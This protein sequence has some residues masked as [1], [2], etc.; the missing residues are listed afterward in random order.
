MF[1]LAIAALLHVWLQLLV[2]ECNALFA[3]GIACDFVGVVEEGYAVAADVEIVGDVHV[4]DAD[5]AFFLELL[6]AVALE[7]FHEVLDDHLYDC[8]LTAGV[9]DLVKCDEV[10]GIA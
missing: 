8:F 9:Q 6:Y 5:E 10:A 2:C 3:K 1:F 7:L 4:A